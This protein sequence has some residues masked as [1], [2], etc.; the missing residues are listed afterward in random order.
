MEVDQE[1]GLTLRTP[2]REAPPGGVI[3]LEAYD[4]PCR[5]RPDRANLEGTRGSMCDV[6]GDTFRPRNKPGNIH[7]RILAE[8]RRRRDARRY[9]E[10]LTSIVIGRSTGKG[11]LTDWAVSAGGRPRRLEPMRCKAHVRL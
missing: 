1:R 5:S 4:T 3:G 11:S 9:L 7:H 10:L 2:E 6:R 8:S